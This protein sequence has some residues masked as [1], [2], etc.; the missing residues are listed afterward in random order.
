LRTRGRP[1][2]K[3]GGLLATGRSRPTP[4]ACLLACHANPNLLAF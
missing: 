2:T 3:R 4:L 1:A